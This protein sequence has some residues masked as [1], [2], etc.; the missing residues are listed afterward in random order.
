MIDVVFIDTNVILDVLLERKP[1]LQNAQRLWSMSESGQ[2][3]GVVSAVSFTNIYYV[4]RRLASREQADRAMRVLLTVFHVAAVDD[5][6]LA[7]AVK[8]QISDFE[9]AVQD[10]CAVR[11]GARCIVTRNE[12]DFANASVAAISPEA[13]L[14]SSNGS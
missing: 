7:H 1:F 11:A 6:V 2:I 5:G 12:R 8:S 3:E 14:S 4:V 10:A 9:D 13:F